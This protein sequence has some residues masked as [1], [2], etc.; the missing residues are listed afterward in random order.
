M[1]TETKTVNC[2]KML[3]IFLLQ[4]FERTFIVWITSF[5]VSPKPSMRLV[6]V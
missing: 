4:S 6:F 3:E 1:Q 2:C 5:S